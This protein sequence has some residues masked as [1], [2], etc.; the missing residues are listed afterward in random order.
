MPSVKVHD[1]V[2]PADPQDQNDEDPEFKVRKRTVSLQRATP[3]TPPEKTAV[4]IPAENDTKSADSSAF[5]EPEGQEDPPEKEQFAS[6]FE[7]RTSKF[8]E[9]N[10]KYIKWGFGILVLIGYHIYFGFAIAYSFSKA[11]A[12]VVM[13]I[14]AWLGVFYYFLLKPKL[15]PVVFENCY[16][17][18]EKILARIVRRWYVKA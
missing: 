4:S 14:I 7:E 10:G 11:V 3:A 16:L 12:L 5:E 2:V 6:R 18:V 13:T 15:G 8:M 9:E 1:I 17:P